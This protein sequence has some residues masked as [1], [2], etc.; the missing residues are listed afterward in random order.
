MPQQ[1]VE[2]TQLVLSF[3]P[4]RL[5]LSLNVAA[6]S[7]TPD[8]SAQYRMVFCGVEPCMTKGPLLDMEVG[9]KLM[10]CALQAYNLILLFAQ[11]SVLRSI[12]KQLRSNVSSFRKSRT[13]LLDA[14][15]IFFRSLYNCLSHQLILLRHPRGDSRRRSPYLL[16]SGLHHHGQSYSRTTRVL[17][18]FLD[19]QRLWHAV[20]C[21]RRQRK[22]QN[23]R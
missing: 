5:I 11:L 2:R 12:F 6:S 19:M 17:G 7:R 8:K 22:L 16:Y 3:I 4:W 18:R 21:N 13:N 1:C 23:L 14:S 15:V 10:P 20:F 9:Y